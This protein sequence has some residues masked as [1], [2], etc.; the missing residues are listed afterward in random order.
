MSFWCMYI[1]AFCFVLC[2]YHEWRSGIVIFKFCYCV[3]SFPVCL[4]SGGS[5]WRRCHVGGSVKIPLRGLW[6]GSPTQ[7]EDLL[8]NV[9]RMTY[10]HRAVLYTPGLIYNGK[11]LVPF[12]HL[13]TSSHPPSCSLCEW[14]R[15]SFF[16]FSGP[17]MCDVLSSSVWLTSLS[18][19]P[20]GPSMQSQTAG[21]LSLF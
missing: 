16:S 12:T 19:M 5:E 3:T 11:L 2:I 9:V 20:S 6:D 4:C 1:C 21:L 18:R 13:P 17:R 15:F 10:S 7:L 8:C 14:I